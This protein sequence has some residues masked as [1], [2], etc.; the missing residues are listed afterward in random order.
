[1]LVREDYIKTI[2]DRLILLSKTI[3]MRGQLHLFDLNNVAE[4]FVAGLLNIKNDWNL[5]NLNSDYGN[6]PAVD[7]GDTQNRVAVQVT[8]TRTTSKISH[9]LKLATDPKHDLLSKYDTI[10][11]FI[12]T[13]KQNIYEKIVIPN[14]FNFN[15]KIHILDW[16]DVIKSINHLSTDK[17]KNLSDFIERESKSYISTNYFTDDSS[18]KVIRQYFNSGMLKTDFNAEASMSKFL[19]TIDA[20]LTLLTTGKREGNKLC[21]A[22]SEFDSKEFKKILES[23]QDKLLILKSLYVSCVKKGD[24]KLDSGYKYFDSDSKIPQIFNDMRKEIVKDLNKIFKDIGEDE[25]SLQY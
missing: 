25:I 12:I 4:T 9:T 19:D 15:W 2:S 17:L 14:G 3:E 16:T 22:Y 13:Y 10:L 7:L 24:I 8:S 20:H 18:I 6:F 23:T 5:V 21:K 11:V 1:M